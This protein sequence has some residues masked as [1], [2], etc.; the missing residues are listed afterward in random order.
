MPAKLLTEKVL[1]DKTKTRLLAALRAIKPGTYYTKEELAKELGYK[2]SIFKNWH[3]QYP[4]VLSFRCF[5]RQ[6]QARVT[7]F[8]H[9][10][11]RKELI[12]KGL[13]REKY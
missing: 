8:V 6:G 12:D 1:Q 5:L 3:E 4:E 13:A 9:P 2:P 7:I 11:T 10:R